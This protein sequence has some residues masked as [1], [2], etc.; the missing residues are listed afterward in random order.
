MRARHL[1]HC[2]E[3]R[4]GAA[5]LGKHFLENIDRDLTLRKKNSVGA[6]GGPQS[7]VSAR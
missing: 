5:G 3:I 2:S 1:G 7:R 6:D 4:S